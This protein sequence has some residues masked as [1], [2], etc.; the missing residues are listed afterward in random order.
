MVRTLLVRG[1][2]AG[3]IAGLLAGVFAYAFGEPRVDAAIL[4]EETHAHA[5]AHDHAAPLVSRDGQRAGL[6]VATALYGLAIGGLFALAFAAVRG[7]VGP[8]DPWALATRL[9]AALFAAAVLVPFVKYPANPPA[10]GDP[11]TI[12]DRT[13]LYLA[14]LACSLLGLLAAARAGRVA[15]LR[16]PSVPPALAGAAT[17]LATVVL[18]CVLLPGVDEVPRDFPASLLWE[19]RLSSLGTQAVLWSALAVA[20]ALLARRSLREGATACACGCSSSATR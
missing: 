8:A 6:F 3:A 10:V 11:A 7:R 2:V 4:L 14:L 1:L 12:G 20:F 15:A 19:F 18:A 17:F 5:H 9:A 13:W 16:T